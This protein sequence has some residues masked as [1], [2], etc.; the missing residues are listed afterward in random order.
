MGLFDTDIPYAQYRPDFL[1]RA[2]ADA[3]YHEL[4]EGLSWEQREVT[5]Y[6]RSV[7]Q[8]RLHYWMADP[9]VRYTYS[10]LTLESRPWANSVDQ[11]RH[12][13]VSELGVGFNSALINYYRDGADS[14][15]WHSDDERDLGVDPIVA[16][17]SLGAERD[18]QIRARDPAQ[19]D[20]SAQNITLEHGSLLIMQAGFQR[21]FQHALPKRKKVTTPRINLTFRAVIRDH[22]QPKY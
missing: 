19:R 18:F 6:G 20:P 13:L 7:P 10:G 2:Q 11:L 1:P 5:I 9:G 22:T 4:R 21:H 12:Q 16:S 8:P 15:G 3:L 14:M 17:I